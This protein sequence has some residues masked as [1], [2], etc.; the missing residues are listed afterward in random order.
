MGRPLNKKWFGDPA[1]PG[2][3]LNVVAFIPGGAGAVAAWIVKQ[4]S[5]TTYT[6][7]D[8][9]DTGRCKLQATV[10]T[11]AGEARIEVSPFIGGTEY[12]RILNAHQVKTFEGNVYSWSELAADAASEA[13][14]DLS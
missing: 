10:P 11:A 7:T 2:N 6:V 5:N 12:V 14:L 3:Q 4:H 8:G 1:G 9:G 13:D